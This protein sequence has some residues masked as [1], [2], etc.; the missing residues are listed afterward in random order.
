[1][2]DEVLAAPAGDV[3][4]ADVVIVGAGPTGL[5]LA[6]ELCLA[7]VRPVV[8]ERLTAISPI[9]KG[10]G[11]VGHI[12]LALDHRGLLDRLRSG[13]TYAGPVPRFSFGPLR[14][15]FAG[16][17]ASPLH[18]LAIPQRRLEQCL[19]DRL[20]ELGGEIRRGHELTG[21]AED[22]DRVALTVHGPA[23]HYELRACYA[24]GCDGAH[25]A[26]RKLAGIGF[27]GVTSEEVTRIG[28]VTL[29]TAMIIPGTGE[30]EVPGAGRLRPAE[31]V[32][33]TG[34]TYSLAPLATLDAAA[35]PGAYIVSTREPAADVSLDDPMTLSEL[36]ASVRR[37]TGADLPMAQPQWLTRTVG[38]SRQ[39]DRYLTG[40]ILLAGD[41]AHL[42]GAGGSLNVG[43]LDAMNLGWK[44]AAQVRGTAPG[45]LLASYHTERH[46][47]GRRHLMQTRVQKALSADGFEGEALR[48]LFGELLAFPEVVRHLGELIEGSGV[49]Y[50]MGAAAD[51][52]PGREMG[53]DH[54]PRHPLTG[55]FVPDIRVAVA[56]RTTRV[57]ELMRAGGF[58]LL[59]LT[60]GGRVGA[61][62]ADWSDHVPVVYAVPV[63]K[64]AP[65]DAVLIR[66]DGH[67]AWASGPSAPD[68]AA[69]LA[70]A[71]TA[72]C[73]DAG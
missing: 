34:G 49:R 48:D 27:P 45:G 1:M 72:W 8:L 60:A 39:A 52:A 57:A 31:Q 68:P 12:V 26:V 64:P 55:S 37:V 41:A 19:A 67:V 71:L 51:R 59:D 66:P 46:A 53:A 23:G 73:G 54:A 14:L 36:S 15:E 43:L 69:G 17:G 30:V 22:A 20:R 58:L 24:V 16:L 3:T 40:R 65:A 62:A 5:M 50:D 56:G 42:F 28:R 33:T 29:P 2:N 10:N 25:S 18:V 70:A 61:T 11:L 21:L 4:G 35:A 63:S 7:G 38:N 6:I 32:R 13:A 44:L 47:A 9:P